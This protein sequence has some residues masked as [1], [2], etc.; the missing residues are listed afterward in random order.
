MCLTFEQED[1]GRLTSEE[2]SHAMYVGHGSRFILGCTCREQLEQTLESLLHPG[3]RGSPWV[4]SLQ[5]PK[6]FGHLQS[7]AAKFA[8]MASTNCPK[9]KYLQLFLL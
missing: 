6:D 8:D 2:L 3:L 7:K 9:L 5:V 4:S 1:C